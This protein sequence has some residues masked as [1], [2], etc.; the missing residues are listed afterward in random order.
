MPSGAPAL[1]PAVA[2]HGLC[3][4]CRKPLSQD[5]VIC[6]ECGLDLR[7]AREIATERVPFPTVSASDSKPD[8]EDDREYIALLQQDKP[9]EADWTIEKVG[10]RCQACRTLYLHSVEKCPKCGGFVEPARC[11]ERFCIERVVFVALVTL[12]SVAA[13]TLLCSV[14]SRRLQEILGP[15]AGIATIGL[16]TP[17]IYFFANSIF[18]IAGL[19]E[20]V[21]EDFIPEGQFF[22][23]RRFFLEFAW[24][25]TVVLV[26]AVTW[27][28]IGWVFRMI[29]FLGPSRGGATIWKG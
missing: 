6:I 25:V 4:K 1:A 27:W 19:R 8:S 22:S 21:L 3:P 15:V 5:A 11:Y 23:W 10:G 7:T 16:L 12:S 2:G 14:D 9:G 29:G 13:L 26:M 18:G 28:F 24:Y 17:F 20:T